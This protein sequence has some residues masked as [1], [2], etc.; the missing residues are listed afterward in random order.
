MWEASTGYKAL[1]AEQCMTIVNV[2]HNL[3][4]V[5]SSIAVEVAEC[6]LMTT[7]LQ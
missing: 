5:S 3:V 1:Q 6:L 4:V 7:G 2:N